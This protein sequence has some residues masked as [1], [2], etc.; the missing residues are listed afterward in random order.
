M[1]LSAQTATPL[2]PAPRALRLCGAEQPHAE[3]ETLEFRREI[4]LVDLRLLRQP[5]RAIAPVA[6]IARD[7]VLVVEH[8]DARAAP[9]RRA[10]PGRAA[11]R[12]HSLELDARNDAAIG[13]P[14]SG[15]VD[16]LDASRIA[17][18]AGRMVMAVCVIIASV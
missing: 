16:A 4:E 8:V 12:H 7:R 11:S 17:I 5:R 6:R 18:S 15:V 1:P 14:P 10:P 3:A 9:D 13:L 2:R